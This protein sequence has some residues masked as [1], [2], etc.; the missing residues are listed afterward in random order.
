MSQAWPVATAR[1]SPPLDRHD[2]DVAEQVEGDL[3][4]VGRDVE[5]HPGAAARVDRHVAARAVAGRDVPLLA[6]FLPRRLPGAAAMLR[7]LRLGHAA[8]PGPA[9]GGGGA[10]GG[11]GAWAAARRGKRGSSEKE[12]RRRMDESP[13]RQI[14]RGDWRRS[15]RNASGAPPLVESG[16]LTGGGAGARARAM[17]DDRQTAS[18]PPRRSTRAAPISTRTC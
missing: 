9:R 12:G 10:T 17:A 6:S 8:R 13:G 3:A 2:I 11:V 14:A 4:A 1:A 15:P 5:R 16:A 7:R 18:R